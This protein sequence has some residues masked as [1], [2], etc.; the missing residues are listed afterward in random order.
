MSQHMDSA[1]DQTPVRSFVFD[2]WLLQSDGTLMRDGQGIHVPP[3]EL[4]VLRLLLAS[5]GTVISKDYLLDSVWPDTDAAEE[6]L[7]RCI[8]ALRKLLKEN[9]NFISTVYGQ[10]FRFTCPVV[11]LDLPCQEFAVTRS[12]AVLPFRGMDET[13]AL[14]L[15]D[16][17][18]RQLTT[19][20]GEAVHVIPSSLMA[21]YDQPINARLLVEQLAADYYVSGRCI[22]AGKQWSI[23]LIRGRDH[24]LLHG[25][26][27][28]G[29]GLEASLEELV[30]LVAQRLP[31]LRPAGDSCSSY[32]A[33]VAYL[34]G[35]CSVQRHT[36]DS[37]RDAFVQ[38]RQCLQLAAGYAPPWCGLADAWLGQA[39]IGLCY[40][41][42]AIE[43][44]HSAISKALMLDPCSTAALT[45][46]ALLTSLRGCEDAAK[47]LFRRCL[48]T[49]DQA[50][51]HYFHAWHHWFWRRNEQAAHS[52][53]KCLRDDPGCVRAQVLRV[54]IA[55]SGSPENAVLMARQ[56]LQRGASGNPLLV[57]LHA[58]VLAYFDQHAAAWYELEQ[59]GLSESAIGEQ[60]LAAW[61]VL[62][63][64]NPLIARNQY[65]IWLRLARAR[66]VE[67]APSPNWPGLMSGP[68]VAPLWRSL[69]RATD[70][71]H[72]TPTWNRRVQE[73]P[74]L[75][76]G[77]LLA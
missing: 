25:Q 34:N 42:R 13:D 48:L 10:G 9:K 17:M 1:T 65:A 64:V 15:Q 29:L 44:A 2:H 46:L 11:A 41:G 30:Y 72:A 37:L 45:R 54:R 73:L 27:L 68:V 74:A 14:D 59:A 60:G 66:S 70:A 40:Q 67:A 38:F 57:I 16:A 75:E 61:N 43:E 63:G 26:M 58:V 69:Q 23:E 31:G 55:L 6:S 5:A 35:V 56:T 4:H 50:D 77:R 32:P 51:V 71:R 49:S 21:T 39:M 7:T 52:I 76:S 22:R 62:F 19:T 8:Y 12:L 36:P 47:V 3:K 33:V 28:G 53:D 18:I 20:F 24:S